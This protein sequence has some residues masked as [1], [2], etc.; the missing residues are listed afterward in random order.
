MI[1]IKT[2]PTGTYYVIQVWS[3]S[4]EWMDVVANHPRGDHVA[5]ALD[6]WHVR[7]PNHEFR[8]VNRTVTDEVVTR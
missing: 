8:L 6:H 5:S 4:G 1:M 7:Y 2:P 3:E